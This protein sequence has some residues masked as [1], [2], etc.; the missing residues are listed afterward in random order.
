MTP[1]PL[2]IVKAAA[3][4]PT[5]RP[6]TSP[7]KQK[8]SAAV[9]ARHITSNEI[10]IFG[11]DRPLIADSSRGKRSVGIIGILQRFESAMPKQ[12]MNQLTKK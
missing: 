11:Y 6:R 9:T 1:T 3:T 12:M 5:P 4:V 2:P 8:V 10:F 7:R